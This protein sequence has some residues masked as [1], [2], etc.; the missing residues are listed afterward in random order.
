V[1]DEL[2]SIWNMEGCLPGL[3]EGNVLKCIR[4]GGGARGL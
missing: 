3:V 1:N 4:G 2:G